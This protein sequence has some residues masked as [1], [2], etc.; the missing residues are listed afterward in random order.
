[1]EKECTNPLYSI[2]EMEKELLYVISANNLTQAEKAYYYAKAA[3]EGQTR[4]EGFPYI[5]HP[6][7]IAYSA[8]KQGVVEDELLAV[9]FLHD[10]CED[11][12]I[13]ASELPFSQRIREAVL[14]LTFEMKA[15]E[16]RDVAKKRYFSKVQDNRIGALVKIFDRCHNI[17]AMCEVYSDEKMHRYVDETEKYVMPLIGL[18]MKEFPEYRQVLFGMQYH[19]K[20]VLYMAKSMINRKNNCLLT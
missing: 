14:S 1:M 3:H 17:S 4:K 2:E 7:T 6:M 10:V 8:V 9:M 18:S 11:C 12:G 20:S 16:T 13:D 15:N 19:M 5:I